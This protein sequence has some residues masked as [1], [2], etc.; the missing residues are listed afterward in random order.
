MLFAWL[1]TLPGAG[2]VGGLAALLSDQGIFGVNALLALLGAACLAIYLLSRRNRI[3]HANV[4]DSHEVLVLAAAT[5]PTTYA[6]DPRSDPL[7]AQEGQ[8]AQSEGGL[9]HIDWAALGTVAVVSIVSSVIFTILLA[10]GIRLVSAAKIKSNEGG[11]STATV[12]LG[13]ILLGL[14]GLLVLSVFT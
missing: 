12:S 14:A 7:E 8:E 5:P 10:S 4:T 3:S 13:Y 6:N 2:L 11:S 1:L 9:M